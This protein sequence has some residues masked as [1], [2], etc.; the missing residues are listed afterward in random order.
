MQLQRKN[1]DYI[2]LSRSISNKSPNRTLRNPLHVLVSYRNLQLLDHTHGLSHSFINL[3]AH[4]KMENNQLA[5]IISKNTELK[6]FENRYFTKPLAVA[7]DQLSSKTHY[8]DDE[9]LKYFKARVLYAKPSSSGLLFVTV[10]SVP[11]NYDGTGRGFRA[12][13]FDLFGESIYRPDFE[14]LQTNTDKALKAF[15]SWLNEFSVL[16]HYQ[17]KLAYE[18][19]SLN[20][21]ASAMRL[22]YNETFEFAEATQ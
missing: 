15:Y 22:A 14:N 17:N 20:A 4:N 12:V 5:Q 18:I 16:N 21:R 2:Y 9:T 19:A 1:N 7:Q 3:K 10:E 8:Y 13:C 6:L 11:K